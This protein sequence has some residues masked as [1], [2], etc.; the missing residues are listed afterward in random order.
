MF[1]FKICCY[2]LNMTKINL[3]QKTIK[4]MS[5]YL[6][7]LTEKYLVFSTVRAE[8]SVKHSFIS[9]CLKYSS[10]KFDSIL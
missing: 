9:P 4:F 1:P 5:K 7:T 3:Q 6:G 10:Y 8:S 2:L